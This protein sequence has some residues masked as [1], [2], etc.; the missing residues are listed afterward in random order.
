MPKGFRGPF[1][2]N[3][4]HP[5][6][7]VSNT[8]GEFDFVLETLFSLLTYLFRSSYSNARVSVDLP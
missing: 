8:A 5:L 1:E 3:T 7:F 4:S 6:L 2:A